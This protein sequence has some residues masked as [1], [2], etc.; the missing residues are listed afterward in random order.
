MAHPHRL[1][2]TRACARWFARGPSLDDIELIDE[3]I[4][5]VHKVL[6]NH[7]DTDMRRLSRLKFGAAIVLLLDLRVQVVRDPSGAS[8]AAGAV[9]VKRRKRGDDDNECLIHNI[10]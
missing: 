7:E 4:G 5:V 1:R 6:I 10:K 9:G 2:C 8:G 3:K